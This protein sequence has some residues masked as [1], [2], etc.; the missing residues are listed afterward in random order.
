M[1]WNDGQIYIHELATETGLDPAHIRKLFNAMLDK[2]L[3][4]DALLH[5]GWNLA[6][7]EKQANLRGDTFRPGDKFI[8]SLRGALAGILGFQLGELPVRENGNA[9]RPE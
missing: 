9:Q 1:I 4:N 3:P 6:E 7:E 2:P 5:A 8:A